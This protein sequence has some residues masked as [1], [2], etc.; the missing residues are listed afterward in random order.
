[1]FTAARPNINNKEGAKECHLPM[2]G[3]IA[4][5]LTALIGG[6]SM[7]WKILL[8]DIDGWSWVET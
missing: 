1:M 5:S 7:H 3:D 8:G 4:T 2:N 6:G